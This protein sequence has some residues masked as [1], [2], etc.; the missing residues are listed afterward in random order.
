LDTS[1]IVLDISKFVLDTSKMGQGRN[2][3]DLDYY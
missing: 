1:K 3:T 2:K